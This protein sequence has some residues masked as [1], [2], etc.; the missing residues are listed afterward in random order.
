[1]PKLE[2]NNGDIIHYKKVGN[3]DKNLIMI[4][5]NICSGEHF[6]PIIPYLSS[7]YTVYIPDLPG[8]GESSYN[9][10]IDKIEGFVD[11]LFEFVSKLKL[12]VFSLLGWSAGGCICMEFAANYPEKVSSLILINSVGY[13]GCPIL[14]ENRK[15]YISREAIEKEPTQIVPVLKAIN[16]YDKNFMSELWDKVI[17][18][19]KKPNFQENINYVNA[20]LKQ[21][22][23][24]DVYWALANFNISNESNGYSN[25]NNKIK[26]I[27]S[28][29]LMLWGEQDKIITKDETLETAKALNCKNEVIILK[30]CGHS[31]FIDCPEVLI[32]HL[33]TNLK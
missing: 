20:S 24:V 33:K 9:N 1:M 32:K 27:K 3:G 22:S 7:N 16:N 6:N 2:M 8:F 29:V 14:D 30:E 25:G 19:N 31:P 28:N 12:N 11:V 10:Q 18:T 4:H 17:Y 5:G 13:K 21:R 15:P 23:L 26:N